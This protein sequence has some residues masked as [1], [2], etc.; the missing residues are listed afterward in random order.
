MP[1]DI[2]NSLTVGQIV[3]W[4]SLLSAIIGGIVWVTIRLYKIFE[5]YHDLKAKNRKQEE[6][7][8]THEEALKSMNLTLE[9]LMQKQDIQLEVMLKQISHEIVLSCETA[10][11]SGSIT[12]DGLES[13]TGLYEIYHN[14]YK[15][16]SYVTALMDRVNALPVVK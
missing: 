6:T 8:A 2:V 14:V 10:L 12:F 5:K 7:L 3:A 9:T 16:N 13:L 4:V 11:T 15:R 1:Q